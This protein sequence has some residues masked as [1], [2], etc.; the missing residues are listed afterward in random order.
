MR[1]NRG[2]STACATTAN[3]LTRTIPN[4]IAKD[5]N[6]TRKHIL[7]IKFYASNWPQSATTAIVRSK[8]NKLKKNHYL[9]KV[10]ADCLLENSSPFLYL[11]TLNFNVVNLG[12]NI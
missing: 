1:Y 9:R 11:G 3:H 8:I 5:L 6:A 10:L 4:I 12:K 2:V 7:K